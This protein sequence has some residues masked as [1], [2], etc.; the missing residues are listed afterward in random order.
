MLKGK[1]R[2]P[3]T[4]AGTVNK[5]ELLDII[6]NEYSWYWDIM[7]S[8]HAMV[9]HRIIETFLWTYFLPLLRYEFLS[10]RSSNSILS[11]LYRNR[12]V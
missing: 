3:A 12:W 5:T 9:I 10:S 6:L 1:Q 11:S 4:A 7:F 8:H 2:I